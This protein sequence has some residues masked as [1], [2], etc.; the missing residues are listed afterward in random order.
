LCQYAASSDRNKERGSTLQKRFNGERRWKKAKMRERKA[1]LCLSLSEMI[2]QKQGWAFRSSP[3]DWEI[4][5]LLR[6]DIFLVRKL[7]CLLFEIFLIFSSQVLQRGKQK[8]KPLL[9]VF[10]TFVYI[11]GSLP[12]FSEPQ[13][14]YDSPKT[15][16]I[17]DNTLIDSTREYKRLGKGK[18]EE[19]LMMI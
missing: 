11:F 18:K 1:P 13:P 12:F 8:R 4:P 2:A 6:V 17:D 10:L 9:F 7:V 16:S 3:S 19:I 14:I 15:E 5:I